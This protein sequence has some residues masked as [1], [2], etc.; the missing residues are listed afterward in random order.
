MDN[1]WILILGLIV[2]IALTPMA[3]HEKAKQEKKKKGIKDQKFSL[4]SRAN[5]IK[6]FTISNFTVNRTNDYAIATDNVSHRFCIVT[7]TTKKVYDFK[8]LLEVE[9]IKNGESITKTSRSSQLIGTVVGGVLLGGVG[10]VIGGLSGKKENINS[11][12]SIELR[13]VLNSTQSSVFDF[14]FF[15][16]YDKNDS[17]DAKVYLD[18]AHMWNN[19]MKAIITQTERTL[20][21]ELGSSQDNS[22]LSVADELLKLKILRDDGI[23]TDEEFNKQKNKILK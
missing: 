7:A 21:E 10:A 16:R 19:I 20:Q 1:L 23:I 8:D 5:E 18:K 22:S 4:R 2:A 9:L 14:V 11:I 17:K 13:L 3:K 6:D 12:N 15:K